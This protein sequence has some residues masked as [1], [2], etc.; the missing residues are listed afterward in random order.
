MYKTMMQIGN[1]FANHLDKSTITLSENSDGRIVSLNSEDTLT[2]ALREEFSHEV[3][4]LPKGDNRSFGDIDVL[5][6]RMVESMN[7]KMVDP[8]TDRY[9]AGGPKVFNYVLYGGGNTTWNGLVKKVKENPPEKIQ[10]EYYYLI[11]YK[12][13]RK[14]SQFVSLTDICRD[15][16]TTN[17]SN[18]LQIKQQLRTVGRTEEE[19][20]QFV[21]EL[22]EEVLYKRAKP[23]FDLKSRVDNHFGPNGSL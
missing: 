5:L 1:N 7:V 12:N 9:N 16:I 11:Y 17:P 22:M 3:A 18:P 15:S 13:S 8:A 23:Y 10:K 21:L 20:L 6:D 4:F 19:K 2:N 14:K